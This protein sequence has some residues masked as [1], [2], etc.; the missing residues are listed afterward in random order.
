MPPQ[1]S[2]R[3]PRERPAPPELAA[4]RYDAL[5]RPGPARDR[6]RARGR[7]SPPGARP[8]RAMRVHGA[9]ARLAPRGPTGARRCGHRSGACAARPRSSALRRGRATAATCR[10]HGR[11]RPRAAR[12]STA[13]PVGSI[14]RVDRRH[15]GG[16]NL[17]ATLGVAPSPGLQPAR[18][19]GRASRRTRRHPVARRSSSPRERHED[20]STRPSSRRPASSSWSC[21]RRPARAALRRRRSSPRCSTAPTP[22]TATRIAVDGRGDE[23]VE[24]PPQA[25]DVR[26]R[27]AA[28]LRRGRRAA[29]RAP[30]AVRRA[31]GPRDAA[32]RRRAT[33]SPCA[34]PSGPAIVHVAVLL[35]RP[36]AA[37]R[38]P[39]DATAATIPVVAA[40]I[41]RLGATATV[42][43]AT[44]C[45][46]VRS[47]SPPVAGADGGDRHPDS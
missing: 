9:L 14:H 37:R 24:R 40:A 45:P 34:S 4:R 39:A 26:A 46:S 5:R 17:D 22:P 35:S 6:S 2:Q 8:A 21:G 42:T 41:E 13:R 16:G 43:S 12:R 23:R 20:R 32:A 30:R 44:C 7:R 36:L 33:T 38:G 10:A 28:V 11:R 1:T 47:S 3:R 31:R 27:D 19:R 18:G 15:N 29:A 25:G